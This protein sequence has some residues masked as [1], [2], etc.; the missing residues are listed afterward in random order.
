MMRHTT[1]G[2]SHNINLS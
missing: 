2:V 1:Q